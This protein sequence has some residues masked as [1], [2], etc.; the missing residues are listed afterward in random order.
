[1]HLIDMRYGVMLIVIFCISYRYNVVLLLVTYIVPLV[2]LAVT[3]ARVGM[4]LWGS[5][6]IGER[7][8]GQDESAKSK[9]KVKP[10]IVE[11]QNRV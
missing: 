2:A 9:R 11:M 6:A 3:Y 7:T 4:E 1:M 10:L 8:A 5:R